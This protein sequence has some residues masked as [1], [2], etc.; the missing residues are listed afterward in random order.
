MLF[1]FVLDIFTRQWLAYR[2]GTLTTT[3]VAAESLA[4]AITAAKLDCPR[5][6]PQA[7]TV[8][9]TGKRFQKAASLL[10]ICL[11]FIC[12]HTPDKT[13]VWNY[14]TAFSSNSTSGHTT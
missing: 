3:D 10:G 7:T 2:F 5:L 14:S 1:C 9:S 6:T 12:T 11:S 8:P 13:A 4:E